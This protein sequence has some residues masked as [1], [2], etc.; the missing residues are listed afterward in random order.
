MT[1]DLKEV[2]RNTL[3]E[4]TK[5]DFKRFKCLLRDQNS[6][7]WGMLEEA[8][9]DDT[10]DLIVQKYTM[11]AGEIVSTILKKMNSNL[12]AMALESRVV[13]ILKALT[14]SSGGTPM[15]QQGEGNSLLSAI[16]HLNPETHSYYMDIM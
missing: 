10:V 13:L 1:A 6:I 16:S 2:L 3:D 11:K 15:P 8:D 4:L 7:P 14:A 9:T 12:L 5:A